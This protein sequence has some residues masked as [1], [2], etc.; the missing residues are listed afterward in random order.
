M[1]KKKQRQEIIGCTFKPKLVNI[2]KLPSNDF[3]AFQQ[4]L[5]LE[6]LQSENDLQKNDVGLNYSQI[7]LDLS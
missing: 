3:P 6:S 7:T 2:K 5:M 4:Y 1:Q